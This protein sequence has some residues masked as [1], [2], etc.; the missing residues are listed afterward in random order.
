MSMQTSPSRQVRSAFRTL[1]L[2]LAAWVPLSARPAVASDPPYP[3]RDPR[4]PL[5][6]VVPW[7]PGMESSTGPGGYRDYIDMIAQSS[8]YTIIGAKTGVGV[9]LLYTSDAADE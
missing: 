6:V 4:C 7:F 2:M 3:I 8:D 1:M 5:P 9:C